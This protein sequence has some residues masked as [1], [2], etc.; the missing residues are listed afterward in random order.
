MDTPMRKSMTSLL[1]LA[2]VLSASAQIS[3]PPVA[4]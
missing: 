4:Q 1:L 2:A 3:S